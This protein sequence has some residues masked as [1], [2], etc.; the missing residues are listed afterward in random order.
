MTV[1]LY[2]GDLSDGGLLLSQEDVAVPAGSFS[3]TYS[4]NT[5]TLTYD[6]MAPVGLNELF[7]ER[8]KG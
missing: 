1:R 7:V 4:G 2:E 3:T 8:L 5:A 6:W